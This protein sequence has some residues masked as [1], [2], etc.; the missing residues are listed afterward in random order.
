M[1]ENQ[2]SVVALTNRLAQSNAEVEKLQH[3]LKR[4]ENCIREHRDLLGVMRNNSQMVHEQVHVLMEELSAHRE[5]VNQLET[6][7]LSEF[8]SIKSILETKIENLKQKT[9]KEIAGL[10]NDSEQKSLQNNKVILHLL[11]H[12]S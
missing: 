12:S 1:A 2:A 11:L 10:Q 6:G 3:E 9:V 7:N 4:D 8:E 5:L